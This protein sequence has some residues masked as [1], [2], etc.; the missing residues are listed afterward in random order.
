M[1]TCKLYPI[2]KSLYMWKNQFWIQAL[3]SEQF[4]EI[5]NNF[6]TVEDSFMKLS[7]EVFSDE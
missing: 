7:Y 2:Q 4:Y 3:H 5:K 6:K 1:Y